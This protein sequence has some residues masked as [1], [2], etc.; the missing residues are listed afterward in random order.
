MNAILADTVAALDH[1]IGLGDIVAKYTPTAADDV[2][3]QRARA[4]REQF[5][6]SGLA[7]ATNDQVVVEI[8]EAIKAN[9]EQVGS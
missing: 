2:F 7:G 9:A 5:I 1:I 6:P 8:A 4:L 3:F